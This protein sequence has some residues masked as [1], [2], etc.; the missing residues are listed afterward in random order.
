MKNRIEKDKS[1]PGKLAVLE[2]QKTK[3]SEMM[4]RYNEKRAYLQPY[5]GLNDELNNQPR[6]SL[7][8]NIIKEYLSVKEGKEYKIKGISRI[9]LEKALRHYEKAEIPKR[10]MVEA[11]LRLVVKFTKNYANRGLD[12]RD[13]IQ[14]GNIG[15]I[16][17]AE[18]YD[19]K[20][21][22]D[23]KARKGSGFHFSTY[24][25]WWIKQAAQRALIQQGHTIDLP[26]HVAEGINRVTRKTIELTQKLGREP[27]LNEIARSLCIPEKT[28]RKLL[29]DHK[30]KDTVSIETSVTDE[31][32]TPLERFLYDK[33]A[34]PVETDAEDNDMTSRLMKIMK[35]NL[36]DREI[37]I[38]K[39]RFGIGCASMTLEELG[40]VF[41]LTRE[42]I[43]QIEGKA[44]RI[45]KMNPDIRELRDTLHLSKG[46]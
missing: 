3:K 34:E 16:R 24:A 26:V 44:M 18:E 15:L 28:V 19:P 22:S 12:F 21:G 2:T 14:E 40:T 41:N 10:E 4:K 33:N 39:M 31:E 45:L 29:Y 38:L 9:L 1:V 30:L 20:Y 23:I 36:K 25:T 5:A 7:Q 13:L 37:E 43:R 46:N 42:R 32:D 17:A 35:E 6:R 11:N 27:F 8:L